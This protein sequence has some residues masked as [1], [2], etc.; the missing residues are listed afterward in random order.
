M[1]LQTYTVALLPWVAARQA[2]F[3]FAVA[4]LQA[5]LPPAV[6]ALQARLPL[7]G[8]ALQARSLD[9]KTDERVSYNQVQRLD[10]LLP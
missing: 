3:P 1:A 5:R 9:D 8:A 7:E 10:P 4:A 2:R 6:A